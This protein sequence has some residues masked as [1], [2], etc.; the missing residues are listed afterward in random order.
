MTGDHRAHALHPRSEPFPHLPALNTCSDCGLQK[1]ADHRIA[2]HLALL[3]S[4]VHLRSTELGART[5]QPS[6][7]HIRLLL[8]NIE[9]QISAVS[10]LHRSLA[11]S[12]R[13]S[14]NLAVHLHDICAPLTEGLIGKTVLTEDF[15]KDCD[16]QAQ[17]VL[18]V[19]QIIAEVVTN[20]AKHAGT[21]G[22]AGRIV[23]RCRK[24]DAGAVVIEVIDNG[25][26]FPAG[27]DPYATG[28]L[29]FRLVKALASQLGAGISFKTATAPERGLTFK[30]DLPLA[31]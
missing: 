26:G 5:E 27:F 23:V 7:D 6:R 30:L 11:V 18:P 13:R 14:T 15:A 4:Y 24:S 29:G 16:I 17:Q 25:P 1:E 19:I 21:T 28:G 12:G 31:A 22:E 9:A 2:N 20:A 3:T 10:R 8:A